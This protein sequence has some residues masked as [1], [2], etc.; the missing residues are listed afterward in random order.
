[1]P[2][3]IASL[4]R[5]RLS[6]EKGTIRKDW[7]GRL[8]VALCYPNS[9]RIGMSN[10]GYQVVYQILNRRE[11]VVAE[12]V[13][14]PEGPEMSLIV[15][16]G[17]GILSLESLSPLHSFD[18]VAFSLSFENDYPNILKILDLA[19]IPS[20][21]DER[22]ERYPLIMAGGITIF[23]NPEPLAPFFDMF[24]VGE[25][26][27][28]LD[29]F[30]DLFAGLRRSVG[31]KRE[32]LLRLSEEIPSV[33]VPS[34]YRVEYRQDGTIRERIP[35]EGSARE[36]IRV[37]HDA[38]LHAAPSMSLIR[39]P[40]TEFSGRILVELGRGCS[41][42]CR[43]CAAG[44]VYRPPRS[45]P[46]PEIL[47]SLEG[48]LSDEKRFGLL[49]PS[50]CDI[51]GIHEITGHILAGGGSFSLSSL[52]ADAL[53]GEMI[54][55]LRQSG[56]QTIAIA[57]EAG[58]ERLRRVI[59]KHLSEEQ[60]IQAVRLI[61]RAG[62]FSI[63]LYF[64][65]GLPTET[66]EDVA[67]V[68]DLVK[69]I[70]HWLVKESRTR[71]NIGQLRLS[72]N[73]LIPK[74]F[75]PFQWLPMEDLKTLKEKQKWLKKMLGR[76]G[77]IK[78]SFD[79]ARWA[80]VQALLSLGD[81]RAGSIL[82]LAHEHRG[83]WAKA[84]RFS[85]INPDFFVYRPKDLNEI[86]PWDFLDHG[87]RKEHLIREYRLALRGEESDTCHPGECFRCGVCRDG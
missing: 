71:G 78:V 25:A 23:L 73:C 39:T 48:S 9:Y 69:H 3:R 45:R 44:Y 79:V 74:S 8:S 36:T 66:G 85:E 1:M 2:D 76:E 43:F 49:A 62:N 70:K 83:D 84:F 52:R 17:R 41:R 59:N 24:L 86:L 37:A 67:G 42:S 56:Q 46:L 16:E 30:V 65:I 34:F 7:G 47:S 54:E 87:I 32:M 60:I 10:L 58:S 55:Q 29:H 33:Y 51:P 12:R 13:F 19:G 82:R 64:L 72:I 11:E 80:Y 61:A 26:E 5:A 75:T 20:G 27:P 35:L 31:G 38:S 81:R 77:G 50:I 22:D 68:L 40:E 53:S 28:I 21:A 15:E 6:K 4:Y 57:P 14:L 63:R 18:L